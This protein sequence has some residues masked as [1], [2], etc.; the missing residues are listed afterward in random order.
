MVIKRI[1]W[2]LNPNLPPLM[3]RKC[4]K[5]D[6]VTLVVINLPPLSFSVRAAFEPTF[7]LQGYSP[8]RLSD[9]PTP[10]RLH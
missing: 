10:L 9:P 1:R 8:L 3:Y 2:G 7:I 5:G 6:P 4:A